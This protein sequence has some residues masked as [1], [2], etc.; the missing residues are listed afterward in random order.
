MHKKCKS[1][2]KIQHLGENCGISLPPVD[3]SEAWNCPWNKRLCRTEVCE[4]IQAQLLHANLAQS[5]GKRRKRKEKTFKSHN[6]FWCSVLVRVPVGLTRALMVPSA[7]SPPHR[8]AAPHILKG[9]R[10]RNTHGYVKS[11][12]CLKCW[13]P[14]TWS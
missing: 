8:E 13:T 7:P 14:T 10:K 1:D 6:C 5:V 12:V 3:L 2:H 9:K 4:G 11:S